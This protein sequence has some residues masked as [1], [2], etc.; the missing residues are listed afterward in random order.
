MKVLSF[1]AT[2]SLLC[3][4]A[5]AQTPLAA[6]DL[7]GDGRVSLAEFSRSENAAML[8]RLDADGDGRISRQEMKPVA[9]REPEGSDRQGRLDRM[10]ARS[11]LDGDGFLNAAELDAAA[12][13]RFGRRDRDKDGWLSASELASQSRARARP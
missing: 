11:D 4:A 5:Y 1:A 8:K 9:D 3:G 12:K 2:V 13:R 10:W 6:A 7:D